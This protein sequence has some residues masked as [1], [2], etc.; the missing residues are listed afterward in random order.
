MEFVS[1][2]KGNRDLDP[3][4]LIVIFLGD[5]LDVMEEEKRGGILKL[6]NDFLLDR[7]TR[8]V[9]WFLLLSLGD[10]MPPLLESIDDA[11]GENIVPVPLF[12][13]WWLF[14]VWLMYL[15]EECLCL[16]F[17]S[18]FKEIQKAVG[19]DFLRK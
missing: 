9:T 15:M 1:G 5:A 14:R 12:L 2:E 7:L 19:T 10:D 11:E 6:L 16:C 4:A 18:F 17:C 8:E 3:Y 13:V